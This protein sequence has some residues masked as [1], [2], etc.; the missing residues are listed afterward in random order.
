MLKEPILNLIKSCLDKHEKPVVAFSGGKDSL[1]VLHLAL[2]IKPDIQVLYNN[3]LVPIPDTL[4]FNKRIVAE[5][6][7]NFLE[8]KPLNGWTFWKVVEKFGFPL[9]QRYGNEATGKCCYH[10]KKAPMKK[11]MKEHGWDLVIDGVTMAESRQRYFTLKDTNGYRYNKGWDCHKLSPIADW[12]P[13]DVWDYIQANNLP[14]NAYY[15]KEL[16]D[17]LRYTKRGIRSKGFYR[18][19]RVGCWSCTIPLKYESNWTTHL[20]TFYPRQ[21]QL[22]LKK[23]L[24]QL[25][26]DEGKNCE[27][28]RNL[29]AEWISEYRPCYFDGVTM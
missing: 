7:L 13:D 2:Q 19:L 25:L 11:A 10:L 1:V 16:E 27:I 18:C 20:R 28:Y 29:T 17:D 9:G 8:V 4:K 24:A 23:G 6:N 26:L 3:T 5:W 21:Y 14:Y 12:T 22:I 15:D